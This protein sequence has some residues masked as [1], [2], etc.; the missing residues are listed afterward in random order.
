MRPV[1][2]DYNATT[3]LDPRVFERHAALL[4]GG[5]R[6]RRKPDASLRAEGEGRGETSPGPGRRSLGPKP[7]E[8]VFTSGATESNNLVLLGLMSTA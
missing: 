1:Y 6:E 5:S 7:E 8:I 3:P 4:P 2:L